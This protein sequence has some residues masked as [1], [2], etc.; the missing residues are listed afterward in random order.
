MFQMGGLL[1]A[2]TAPLRS[3]Q[4]GS[5]QTSKS[6]SFKSHAHLIPTVLKSRTTQIQMIWKLSTYIR[7]VPSIII[8]GYLSSSMTSE[9]AQVRT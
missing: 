3:L 8:L 2:Q 5:A 1:M 4:P 9:V 7:C 6:S